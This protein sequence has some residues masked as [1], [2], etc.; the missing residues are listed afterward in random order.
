M[1]SARF[2]EIYFIL[3]VLKFIFTFIFKIYF[4]G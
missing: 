3:E 2:C 1:V 4:T